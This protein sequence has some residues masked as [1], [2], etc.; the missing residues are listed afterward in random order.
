MS[1]FILQASTG[2]LPRL[3]KDDTKREALRTTSLMNITDKCED[4]EPL[5]FSS[6]DTSIAGVSAEQPL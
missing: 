1:Q 6:I 3:D 4:G 2:L 5:E